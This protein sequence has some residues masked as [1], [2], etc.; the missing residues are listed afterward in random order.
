MRDLTQGS[1]HKNFLI[2]SIPIIISSVLS[3]AFGVINTSIAGL[4]LG[5]K[6]IA[7]T[8]A[9]S[10]Y[11]QI[12]YS[13]FFGFAYGMAV[14]VGNLFGAKEY[15]RLKKIM[16][17]T[18]YLV[19]AASLLIGEISVFLWRPVFAFLK[20]EDSIRDDS[21]SYYYLMCIHLV[22][23]MLNH[24]FVMASNAIGET[25]FPLYM[26]VLCS[27]L[28][29]GG[30]FL[31]V[32][33]FDF[34]VLGIGVSNILAYLTVVLLYAVRFHFYFKN[35]GVHKLRVFPHK[36]YFTALLPYSIPNMIQQMSMYLGIL[37]MAP[38]RNGLGYAVMASVSITS[39][40]AGICTNIYYA[41]ARTSSNYIAQCV[42]A[43]KYENIRK[44]VGVAFVQGCFFFLPILLL[45][46][47]F[48]DTVCG[49]FI[50]RTADPET[51]DYAKLYIRVFLPF[52]VC[53][54]VCGI[55]HSVFRGIK[56][57]KHLIIAASVCTAAQVL[58]SYIFTPLF[59]IY[60][61][62]AGTVSGWAC[63]AVY[64]LIIYFSGHWVPKNI[65]LRV[66]ASKKRTKVRS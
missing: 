31:A 35:M 17:S 11:F 33:I 18:F 41:S 54:M 6:G 7:A 63:E 29:I 36:R 10:A 46:W 55:F 26:S 58:V 34:G 14:Y 44:A 53:N 13:V 9:S 47:L 28:T 39:Q 8:S 60:G 2:F 16:M 23:A 32:G 52:I 61:L 1:I 51:W 40:I 30:N 49:M 24:F 22:L 64:V 48:P 27:S 15:E 20:I 62:F 21:L 59:G 66:L 38:V 43:R 42:G 50:D 65:R 4:F 12:I 37:L 3:S 57:N 25:R 19:I 56:A 5:A 45:M